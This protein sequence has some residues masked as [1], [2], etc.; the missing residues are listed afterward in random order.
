[1]CILSSEY[2]INL[3]GWDVF[4]N[5]VTCPLKG[6]IV[7]P[8]ETAVASRHVMTAT[9]AHATI[10][11]FLC[12]PC[13]GYIARTNCHYERVLTRNLEEYMVE[14]IWPPACEDVRPEAEDR[15]LLKD[16]TKQS[17]EDRD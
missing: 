3:T 10:Q 9:D 7:K 14:M 11:C 13:R 4:H 17:S 16:V 5:I 15:P 12:V 2:N 8:A 1:L 6:R